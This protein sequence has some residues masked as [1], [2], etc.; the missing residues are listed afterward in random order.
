MPDLREAGNDGRLVYFKL[1]FTGDDEITFEANTRY[2]FMV[3]IEEAGNDANFTL[4]N[5]NT[6]SSPAPPRMTDAGMYPGGWGLRREGRGTKPHKVPG[7]SPPEDPSLLARLQRESMFG[8]LEERLKLSPTSD[9][10]PD[11]DT[12]RDLEFY[13]LNLDAHIQSGCPDVEIRYTQDL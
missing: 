9:G 11:V 2:A 4:A 12:Y 8:P 7:D 10:Y 3:G 5:K 1:D 6:A 13:I